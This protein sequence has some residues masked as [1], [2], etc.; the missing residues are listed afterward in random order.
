VSTQLATQQY[1]LEQW[2]DIIRSRVE[3]GMRVKDFCTQH[4]LSENAYYYW[5]RKVRS[6][7]ISEQEKMFAEL[8]TPVEEAANSA[9]RADVIIELGRAR[10]RVSNTCSR[11]TLSMVM[12]VLGDA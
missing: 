12:E 1:R 10:V 8:P 7:A 2:A 5:L 9:D 3:S 4:D 6:A 11:D